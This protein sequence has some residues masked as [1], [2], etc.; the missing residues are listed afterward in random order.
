MARSAPTSTSLLVSWVSESVMW[1][2]LDHPTI[3]STTA[4]TTTASGTVL[5]GLCAMVG[6]LGEQMW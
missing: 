3:V 4:A 2:S 5:I 6:L 1:S